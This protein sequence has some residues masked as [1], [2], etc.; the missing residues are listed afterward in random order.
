MFLMIIIII[1]IVV[2]A[3]VLSPCVII[4]KYI[5]SLLQSYFIFYPWLLFLPLIFSVCVKILFVHTAVLYDYGYFL[6]VSEWQSSKRYSK[7]T[8]AW[9]SM[10]YNMLY[11][12]VY[13]MACII[14]LAENSG[15]GIFT[16]N[17]TKLAYSRWV[18]PY[19]YSPVLT[20]QTCPVTKEWLMHTH[21]HLQ[22][23][24]RTHICVWS[25]CVIIITLNHIIIYIWLHDIH[26][27]QI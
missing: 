12:S 21:K 25:V 4:W 10:L 14:G 18:S 6:N 15:I 3:S 9:Y 7:E 16:P 13:V 17:V 11:I 8:V 2:V 1:I 27:L 22:T 20:S 5:S 24:T 19:R 26:I 23:Y